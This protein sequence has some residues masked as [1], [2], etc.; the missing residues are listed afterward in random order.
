MTLVKLCK[1]Y[2]YVF[3]LLHVLA[4][5]AGW[6]L[7]ELGGIGSIIGLGVITG[8]GTAIATYKPNHLCRIAFGGLFSIA[9]VGEWGR[10]ATWLP[11][12]E[13]IQYYLVSFLNLAAAVAFFYLAEEEQP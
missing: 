8:F 3:A 13:P 1:S 7:A 9:W 6:R 5:L 11:T 12:W 2:L 4:V 10:I